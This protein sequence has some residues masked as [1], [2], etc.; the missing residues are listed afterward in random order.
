MII[1]KSISMNEKIKLKETINSEF[2]S[3]K[4]PKIKL[5]YPHIKDP[6][7]QSKI[8]MKQEFQYKYDGEMKDIIEE[9]KS[10]NLCENKSNL[11]ELSPHQQFVK[12]FMSRHTP[13]NGLLLYHGMGSGKTCSAIGITEEFRRYNKYNENYKNRDLIKSQLYGFRS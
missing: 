4:T 7:L 1:Y 3:T 8:S 2:F 11:F 10:N 13:Y 12:T 6:N 9:D 5:K